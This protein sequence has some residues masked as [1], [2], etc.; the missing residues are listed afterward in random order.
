MW[1]KTLPEIDKNQTIFSFKEIT[2]LVSGYII[3]NKLRLFDKR[4][5]KVCIVTNDPLGDIFGLDFF[6]HCQFPNLLMKQLIP[7]T[8]NDKPTDTVEV[9][10]S[11]S[12][13]DTPECR[14]TMTIQSWETDN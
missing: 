12:C 1:M 4:N 6:H 2:K 11:G 9:R 14:V 7:V 8:E 5:V 10:S 3:K 13:T